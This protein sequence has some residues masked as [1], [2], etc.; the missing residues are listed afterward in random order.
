MLLDAAARA[1][2]EGVL[3]G[4]GGARGAGRV[5]T[6]VVDFEGFALGG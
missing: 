6:L 4:W 2:G 3:V 1:G 5:G